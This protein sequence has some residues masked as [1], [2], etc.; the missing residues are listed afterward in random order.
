MI[1]NTVR[2]GQVE[3]NEDSVITFPEGIPGFPSER[4]F[5]LLQLGLE[6]TP[7]WW[8]QSVSDEQLCFLTIEP[9]RVF[10]D[11]DFRVPNEQL[12]QLQLGEEPSLEA[13]AIVNV[14][15]GE[16]RRATVNLRA[17]VLVNPSARLG[18]QVILDR[19]Q[20]AIRQQL[21]PETGV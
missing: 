10:P 2:F 14:P 11:Y 15:D 8:L 17:P 19:E 16:L 6:E 21:F 12:R 4:D 1:I 13:L 5:I 7:F 9:N 18:V 3:V 20:Y